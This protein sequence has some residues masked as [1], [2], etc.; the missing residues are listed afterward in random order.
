MSG[1]YGLL[2]AAIC[3]AAGVFLYDEL[4]PFDL[5]HLW[6]FPLGL[7]LIFL[8]VSYI[9]KGKV[10]ALLGGC[11]FLLALGMGRM[12]MADLVW[13]RQSSW[14][15]GSDG[16]FRAIVMEEPLVQE[17]LDGYSRYLVDLEEIRYGDG[18]EKKLSGTAYFYDTAQKERFRPGD[19][20]AM[21]GKLH[22]IRLYGNPGKIDLEGRYRSR[23]LL[24]RIYEA[25]RGAPSFVEDSGAY[26]MERKAA[27]MK[28][29]LADSFAPY[30]DVTRLHLLM[31]LLFG[32]SY[33]EIPEPVMTSFQTTGIIHILS[34]SGSHVALLFG[35]LYFLGKWLR[36]PKKLVII[37]AIVVV[38]FYAALSGLVPPVIRAA[39]MG[40]LSVGGV[41]LEREK[42]TLNL[43]GAAVLGMLLWDPFYLYDVSFQLSVG[44]SAGIL[45]F[46][47]PFLFYLQKIYYLKN[48][49]R[50]GIALSMAAQV[51]T[52][53]IVLYDF[54]AFPLFFIPANLFVTPFLEWVII[55]GLL[56]AAVSLLF[57]PL[58]G[59]TLY[60]S[61]Y[62]MWC[63]LR[64]NFLLSS[65]PKA[66]IGTG[67][68]SGLAVALYYGT[69]GGLYFHKKLWEHRYLAY[70]IAGAWAALALAV[71]ISWWMTP[72]FRVY[73]PDLG[74]DRGMVLV[75]GK[76]NILYYKAS[77]VSSHTANW[78]WNSFLG[79]EGIFDADV[80]IINVENAKD[81]VPLTMTI[82]IKEIWVT[83]N[84]ALLSPLW[85]KQAGKRRVMKAAKLSL[86]NLTFETNGS[87]W[88]IEEGEKEIY[89]SGKK[90]MPSS[91]KVHTL[92][93][94]GG[95]FHMLS[96]KE[97]AAISPDVVL[98]GGSRLVNAWEDMELFDFRNIPAVNLYTEGAQE[99]VFEGKWRAR[100]Q[101][102]RFSN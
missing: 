46:Y 19:R 3:F 82:P 13:S 1:A 26:R 59:G 91:P 81:T 11:L 44:A 30:M 17:G 43:L 77:G 86:G 90:L 60:V 6:A 73:A 66:S 20:I 76:Q 10:L 45:I 93:L 38:L 58:A 62:L 24:G 52:L 14:A 101:G 84:P 33:N 95:S 22:P 2:W 97:I 4:P 78:E 75:N 53:P 32:G 34:V 102:W 51:L 8:M 68:M 67:G 37:G 42:A 21:E 28:K 5:S 63:G 55:A 56:A 89:L 25:D 47:R 100:E 49:I 36:L 65:L 92:L 57:L 41:F 64:L 40:I 39:V 23:R 31:T 61:D 72:S 98:Y 96:E 9:R 15:I 54:H 18:V 74:A 85:E 70:G 7:S 79:Y 48:W 50:E 35:F 71:C 29:G 16:T 94:S 69:V 88:R 83:G 99:V 87:T 27:E 80:L 12:E